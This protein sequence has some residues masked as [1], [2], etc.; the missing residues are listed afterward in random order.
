MSVISLFFFIFAGCIWV[1]YFFLPLGVLFC[2]HTGPQYSKNRIESPKVLCTSEGPAFLKKQIY[3]CWSW[4]GHGIVGYASRNSAAL[5]WGGEKG[6]K[7]AIHHHKAQEELQKH[8]QAIGWSR[9]WLPYSLR[10]C[11]LYNFIDFCVWT[12]DP[13]W[14]P[15]QLILL[16]TS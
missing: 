15:K 13:Y 16:L 7:G 14:L 3:Y 11:L 6:G 1:L 5:R 12:L 4:W 8:A 10:V 9:P 2:T